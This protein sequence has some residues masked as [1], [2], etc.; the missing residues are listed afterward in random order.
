MAGQ[1][2]LKLA[3][4]LI[5]AHFGDLVAKVCSCLLRRGTLTLQEIIRFTELSSSQVKN[6]LLVLIQHNCVQAFS[7]P[8]PA[9]PGGVAKAV[10]QY[11]ALFDNILHRMRFAKFLAV[12]REDLGP[13][14]CVAHVRSRLGL[15]AG[16]V[17]E[18]MIESSGQ[19]KA[20]DETPGNI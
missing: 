6:C 12:I 10:T 20:K 13:Q 7:T 3:V 14:A 9:G 2:G 15:D 18:A 4:S 19:Q 5:T 17:L 8:R 1:C 16:V 11:M